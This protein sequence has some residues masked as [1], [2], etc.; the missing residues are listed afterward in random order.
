LLEEAKEK[1]QRVLYKLVKCND[2]LSKYEEE[3]QKKQDK[4]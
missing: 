4:D 1:S 3:D 2:K